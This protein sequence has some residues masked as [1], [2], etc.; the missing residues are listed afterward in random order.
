MCG[1]FA[2]P[3]E[4]EWFPSTAGIEVPA[5]YRPNYNVAPTQTVGIIVAEAPL[6]MQP[7]MF[8]LVPSWS[9]DGKT[10]YSMLNAKAES[11]LEKQTWKTLVKTHRCVIPAG[12]YY[13]WKK[14][15]AKKHPF[16]IHTDEKVFFLAGLWTV[17]ENHETHKVIKSFSIITCAP[18]KKLADIHDRMPVIL[19]LKN[20]KDWLDD[21]DLEM[22]KAFPASHMKFYQVSD[23]VGNVR[24]NGPE[25]LK[26]IT[27]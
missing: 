15:G 24:N 19:T 22:L 4:A 3:V 7:A 26:P 6:K 13:E 2:L 23:A 9:K 8:G 11:L 18:N 16:Y 21:G 25:L 27:A 14:D 20:Y 12:G 10:Q 5:G 1:R 17:W